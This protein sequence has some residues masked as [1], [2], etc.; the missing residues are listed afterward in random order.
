MRRFNRY[1]L[2]ALLAATPAF[3]QAED[4][5]ST[6]PQA[7]SLA[8]LV[9][10]ALCRNP[11]TQSAWLSMEQKRSQLSAARSGYYPSVSLS[12][13]QTRYLDNATPQDQSTAQ[14]SLNWLLFDFGERKAGVDA[15]EA[16]LQAS[17]AS[18]DGTSLSVFM[19]AVEAYYLWFAARSALDAAR[20]SEQSA[21]ETLK[22]AERRLTLGNAT[23]ED[24]LQARTSLS[25]AKLSLIRAEG[26]LAIAS[27]N[28]AIALGL[29]ADTSVALQE[30][31]ERR[32]DANPPASLENLLQQAQKTRPD[33]LAQSARILAAQ[34]EADQ[35]RAA[36]RPSLSFFAREQLNRADGNNG[37]STAVG[38]SLSWSVFSGFKDRYSVRSAEQQIEIEQI[39]EQRLQQAAS[40]EIWEA[41]QNLRTTS[42]TVGATDD[43]VSSASEAWRGALARYQAGVGTL[44]NVLDSQSKL[45]SA[46]EQQASALYD[47]QIA[48]VRLAR[49]VGTLDRSLLDAPASSSN[50]VGSTAAPKP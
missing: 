6:G 25:Q 49:V 28:V 37:D 20:E 48:R 47:W 15:A 26:D 19:Q 39:E 33:L 5:P 16:L 22:A 24:V 46:R 3:A 7:L 17:A 10:A 12:A 50:S 32:P 27:G 30:P 29:K 43:L 35:T 40:Q 36:Y 42:A 31:V 11:Q 34:A 41:R 38:L 9:S 23:R 21:A 14:L 18:K 45:A 2:P 8:E 44:L 4:C 13:S 1:L